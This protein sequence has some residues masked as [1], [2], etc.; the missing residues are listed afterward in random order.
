MGFWDSE[1]SPCVST[2]TGLMRTF[3]SVL[4]GQ[5]CAVGD[6]DHEHFKLVRVFLLRSDLKAFQAMPACETL[7]DR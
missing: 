1:L 6:E 5:S 2:L 7:A 3:A 4:A